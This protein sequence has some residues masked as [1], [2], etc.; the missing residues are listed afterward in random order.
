M[1]WLGEFYFSRL[2]VYDDNK[3]YIVYLTYYSSCQKELLT[4]KTNKME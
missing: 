1:L 3:D 2:F 4:S